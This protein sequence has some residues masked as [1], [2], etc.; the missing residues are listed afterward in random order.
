MYKFRKDM[1]KRY[2]FTAEI[3]FP[4]K[5]K[6]GNREEKTVEDRRRKLQEFLRQFL[7]LWMRNETSITNL[8]QSTLVYLF[9]F[10]G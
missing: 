3:H 9:P 10:F 2:P 4:P 8:S 6:F 5:K 1:I 7:N